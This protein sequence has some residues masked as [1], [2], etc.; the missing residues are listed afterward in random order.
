VAWANS[1]GGRGALEGELEQGDMYSVNMESCANVCEYQILSS[2]PTWSQAVNHAKADVFASFLLDID[3][4]FALLRG[5]QELE[6]SLAV[7]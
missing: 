6:R 2:S 5:H 3:R 7:L 1:P 4:A